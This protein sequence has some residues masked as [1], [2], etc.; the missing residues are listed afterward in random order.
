MAS[1]SEKEGAGNRAFHHLIRPGDLVNQKTGGPPFPV[2]AVNDH[3]VI[4]DVC[5]VFLVRGHNEIERSSDQVL[6]DYP[7]AYRQI[8]IR[9]WGRMQ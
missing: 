9:I 5:G 4:V 2:V 8:A 3:Q 1:T 7:E 6:K